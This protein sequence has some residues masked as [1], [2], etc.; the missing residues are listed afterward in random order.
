MALRKQ[1]SQLLSDL[2]ATLGRNNDPGVRASDLAQLQHAINLA[3]EQEYRD[4]DWPHLRRVFPRIDLAAGQR[5]YDLP[6]TSGYEMD[7]DRME[8][9][10]V[11]HNGIPIPIDRGIG[12]ED[13]ATYDS[14]NDDRSDPVVKWDIRFTGTKEQIEVWPLPAGNAQDLQFIGIRKF[15]SLVDDSD[16]CMLDDQ[17]VVLTAAQLVDTVEERMRVRDVALTRIR[18]SLKARS[19]SASQPVRVGLGRKDAPNPYRAT[20]RISG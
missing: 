15:A 7:F 18:A 6:D 16:Q 17:L 9:V 13:Y 11:W 14:E 10:A 12:F 3:Y 5:Y 8:S 4:Y 1:F 19:K 20:I 2:R